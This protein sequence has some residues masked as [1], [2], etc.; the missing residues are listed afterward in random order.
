MANETLASVF[1][2]IADAIRERDKTT[3][4]I[5][6]LEMADRIRNLP[7]GLVR[8]KATESNGTPVAG[9]VVTM[10]E[11]F[12]VTNDRGICNI[13]SYTGT[14]LTVAVR[15]PIDYGAGL[16]NVTVPANISTFTEIPVT[17]STPLAKNEMDFTESCIAAFSSRVKD[18]DVF[19][20]GAGGSG[21]EEYYSTNNNASA[22]GGSAGGA[23]T[24][25]GKTRSEK[26][27]VIT[28]GKGGNAA[29]TGGLSGNLHGNPG[30]DSSVAVEGTSLVKAGGGKGGQWDEWDQVQVS[31]GTGDVPGAKCGSARVKSSSEEA[32]V[33]AGEDSATYKFGETSNTRYGGG[34]GAVASYFQDSQKCSTG[35][36]PGGGDGH[37][38]S[39]PGE[40][41]H[42]PGAGGGAVLVL[43]GYGGNPLGGSG[44]DGLVSFRWRLKG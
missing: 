33:T 25:L 20:L 11:S 3:A 31:G 22:C 14:A 4:A 30:G 38:W 40:D 26:P 42:S 32:I 36:S 8:I 5:P 15:S 21:A 43:Y 6:A 23:S 1:T 16:Q 34:G 39:T 13:P 35:G 19:A 27:F 28:V 17:I 10:G 18:F 9:C 24:V 44:A 41:G 2:G 12:G 29:D 7:E 37:E